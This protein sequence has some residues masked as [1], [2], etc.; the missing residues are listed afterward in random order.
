MMFAT[1][2]LC[3]AH[4]DRLAAGTL[5]VLEPV[6]RP[7]GGVRRFAGPAATLKLFED[8]SL[9][10][11]ALEQDGAGRVLVGGNLGKLAEKNGWAGI[12]V[13]GCV[14]DSDELA[15]CRVGVLALAAHPRKS[16]KRGAGVSDAPVDVRGTRI[17]PGDWIY[18]DA[19]GVLVSDDALLE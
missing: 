17:V 7:F 10:R 11:T 9:V 3:D 14:R 18:A 4:E 8:N 12:V 13:N 1:T 6:F 15:E 5:R 19:D 16:D 2:D